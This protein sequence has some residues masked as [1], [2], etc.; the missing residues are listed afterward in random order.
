MDTGH[1]TGSLLLGIWGTSGSNVFTVGYGGKILHYNGSSWSAM[2]SHTTEDLISVWGTSPTNIY[3]SGGRGTVLH[4]NGTTWASETSHTTSN[5]Q[6]IWG[7]SAGNI[8]IAGRDSNL[9]H[10]NGSAWANTVISPH[11]PYAFAGVWGSSPENV[12]AGGTN[13]SLF[14]YNGSRWSQNEY[15]QNIC[16]SDLF[17][18]WGSSAYDVFVVG[19]QG[20]ILHYRCNA[21]P[22]VATDAAT[23]VTTASATLT[24]ALISMGSSSIVSVSF[25]YGLNPGAYTAATSPQALTAAGPFSAALSLAGFPT[26]STIYFRSCGTGDNG[27]AAYGSENSFTLPSPAPFISTGPGSG[28]SGTVPFSQAPPVII[29]VFTTQ[30]ALLSTE[31]V[32][33]GTPVTVTVMVANAGAARGSTKI[34]LLVDGREVDCRGIT[35]DKGCMAPVT[36]SVSREQPG[37]YTVS[38]GGVNA[39]SFTVEETLNPD[40]VLYISLSMLLL[41]IVLGFLYLRRRTA[42]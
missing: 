12:F 3:A 17:D 2:D 41:S 23:G 28:S 37:T 8:Y 25:Q 24:G 14:L 26:G 19:E 5:L 6:S 21:P 18:I 20:A 13:G 1:L 36:F 15:I 35:L 22:S 33:P 11:T 39:G 9:L 27:L 40:T 4:Y 29:P 42:R 32:S 7:S 16:Q 10:Y 38:A 31:R 34:N 30:S